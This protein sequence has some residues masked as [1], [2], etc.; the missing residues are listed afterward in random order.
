MLMRAVCGLIRLDRGEIAIDGEVLR[1]DISFPRSVGVLIES[2][3]FIGNY[4]GYENLKTLTAIK[5]ATSRER[6][7]E[8]LAMVGLDA[9][10]RKPFRKYSLGMKQKLGIAAAIVEEP[11]LLILDEPTNALDEGS[12]QELKRILKQI[13]EREAL[14]LLS[15]HDAEDLLE[16]SDEVIEMQDGKVVSQWSVER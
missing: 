3:G 16:L 1:K 8:S 7:R 15:C 9:Q 10:D 4:S 5:G 6:I 2:P 11:D 13:K 12:V 14:I